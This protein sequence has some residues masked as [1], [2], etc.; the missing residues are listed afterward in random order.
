MAVEP[1]EIK[2]HCNRCGHVMWFD[3]KENRWYCTNPKCKKYK[4]ENEEK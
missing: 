4:P 2:K 1:L 3:E